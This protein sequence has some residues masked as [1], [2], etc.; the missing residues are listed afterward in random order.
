MV[1]QIHPGQENLIDGDDGVEGF[2][3]PHNP[4]AE[5]KLQL[6]GL[7]AALGRVQGLFRRRSD[8]S[9]IPLSPLFPSSSLIGRDGTKCE[10]QILASGGH[11][12][13]SPSR[14]QTIPASLRHHA[15]RMETRLA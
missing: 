4:G 9:I 10:R 13:L 6:P 1:R 2:L 5:S 8:H 12:R 11:R 15:R 14:F 3:L 7:R